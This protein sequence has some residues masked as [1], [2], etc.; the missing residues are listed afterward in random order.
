MH[1][2]FYQEL[3]GILDKQLIWNFFKLFLD[4]YPPRD[5]NVVQEMIRGDFHLFLSRFSWKN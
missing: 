4:W 1:F 5:A 2:K 3:G